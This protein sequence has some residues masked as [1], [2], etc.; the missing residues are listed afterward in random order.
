MKGYG[1]G[2][3]YGIVRDR[4][5]HVVVARNSRN[6]SMSKKLPK[7]IRNSPPWATKSIA[8]GTN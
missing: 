5:V 6:E 4:V 1:G 8:H 3:W 7:L 2:F